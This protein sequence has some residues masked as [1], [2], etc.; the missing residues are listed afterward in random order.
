MQH[1]ISTSQVRKVRKV[2]RVPLVRLDQLVQP[3]R[4]V[5]LAVPAQRVRPAPPAWAYLRADQR[6]KFSQR[7]PPRITTRSGPLQ[8]EGFQTHQATAHTTGVSMGLGATSPPSPRPPSPAIQPPP[9]KPQETV[10]QDLQP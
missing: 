9:L 3:V 7:I 4:P 6:V 8:L 2:L 10:L 1:G 5:L